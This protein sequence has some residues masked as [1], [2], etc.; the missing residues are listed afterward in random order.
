MLGLIPVCLGQAPSPTPAPDLTLTPPLS[1]RSEV[2]L[3]IAPGGT[4]ATPILPTDTVYVNW[5]LA[6]I[7]NADAGAFSIQ[8]KLDGYV[9]GTYPIGGLAQ[10]QTIPFHDISI[11]SLP[12]GEHEVRV[13]V[14]PDNTVA[15]SDELYNFGLT[16]FYVGRPVKDINN[17]RTS[18]LVWQNTT[19]GAR[20]VWTMKNGTL[21]QVTHFADIP[22]D[23]QIAAVGDL[24]GDG[25]DDLLWQNTTTGDRDLW[26][27]QGAGLKSIVHFGP[28]PLEWRIAGIGDFEGAGV[29]ND[30]VWQNTTTG[31]I[32]IWFMN[33]TSL[34]E[35]Y[36]LG[37]VPVEWQIAAVGNLFNDFAANDYPNVGAD[38][39]WQNLQTGERDLWK[40]DGRTLAGVSKLGQV[41]VEWQIAGIGD[42]NGDGNNDLIWQNTQTGERDIWLMDTS[43]RD[44]Y[45]YYNRVPQITFL[46][47]EPVEWSIANH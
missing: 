8:F 13:I 1:F 18:D 28:I 2:R 6:N 45:G 20:D 26:L 25:Q 17:D 38:L 30:I 40:M 9:V 15:E 42:F 24:D 32:D 41:P 35:V 16:D 22:T 11:G 5:D 19:T 33:G 21:Y 12:Q 37:T 7:G 43:G 44:S 4:N 27:M 47:F 39:I 29:H 14:D 46:G 36:K 31:E 23:W 34:K 10:G 3:A